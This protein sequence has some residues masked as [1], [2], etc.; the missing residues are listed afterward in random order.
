VFSFLTVRLRLVGSS[1][2]SIAP[3]C[4]GSPFRPAFQPPPDPGRGLTTRRR[5]L[6]RAR[7]HHPWGRGASLMFWGALA[8]GYMH[9]RQ[10]V[11]EP[12]PGS[13]WRLLS[14]SYQR[15]PT[16]SPRW[17]PSGPLYH[18]DRDVLHALPFNPCVSV[19]I[20]IAAK[21]RAS[22]SRRLSH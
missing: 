6:R 17:K 20:E 10:P 4:R 16:G 11:P 3:V 14:L 5:T 2:P 19:L 18:K 13:A 7:E 8:T 1:G 9:G 15:V 12:C 22:V 21:H